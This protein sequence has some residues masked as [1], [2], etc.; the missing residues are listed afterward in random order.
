MLRIAIVGIGWAGTRHVEALRELG[1][2][3][4]LDCI[5]DNDADFL[6]SASRSVWV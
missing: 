2:K 1:R 3:I 6:K 4:A 5:V